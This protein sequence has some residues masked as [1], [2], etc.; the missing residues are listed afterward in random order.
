M[1]RLYAVLFFIVVFFKVDSSENR[2][3]RIECLIE[4]CRKG[5]PILQLSE[6]DRKCKPLKIKNMFSKEIVPHMQALSEFLA[7]DYENKK[8]ILIISQFYFEQNLTKFFQSHSGHVNADDL[9]MMNPDNLEKLKKQYEKLKI[10]REIGS[11]FDTAVDVVVALQ[12]SVD[13]QLAGTRKRKK[14]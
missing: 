9:K 5:I 12:S 6:W 3:R 14:Q 1:N 7:S 8:R 4:Q 2:E 13:D 11:V 10:N